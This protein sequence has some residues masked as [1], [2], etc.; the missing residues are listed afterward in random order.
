MAEGR[1][2]MR[3]IAIKKVGKPRV[4]KDVRLPLPQP[5]AGEALVKVHAASVNPNDLLYRRGRLI[6]RKPMP[7]ILGGDV[8]GEIVQMGEDVVGWS[9]GDRVAAAFDQLGCE[10]DGSYAEYCA[11]PAAQLVKLP[12]GLDYQM[13][14]AAGA[15]FV[16]A[17]MAL[18]GNGSIARSDRVVIRA[19]A[20]SIGTS[21]VQIASAKG[22]QVIAVASGEHTARLREIGADV[23]LDDAGED[24]VR[25]VKVATDEQGATLVLHSADSSHFQQSSKMLGYKGRLVMAHPSSSRDIRLSAVDV[26]RKNLSILGAGGRLEAK[27]FEPIL[28]CLEQ[29]VYRAVVDEVMP[30]SQ[31]RQAHEKLEKHASFGKIV[32]V[33]DA[34]LKAAS[35]PSNWIPIE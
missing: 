24:L 17:W 27:D 9:S 16:Q 14:V 23:V 3:A 7:H 34:I 2:M 25:Q 22:A 26:Y 35:K 15:A 21:A 13:A 31:A 32:L 33:P 19:A 28:R 5:A 12:N 1:Q 6:I 10:R 11:I 4:L 29:G 30:L 8:A 20:T 18:V